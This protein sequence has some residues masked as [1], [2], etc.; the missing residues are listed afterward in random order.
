MKNMSNEMDI[1]AMDIGGMTLKEASAMSFLQWVAK[2]LNNMKAYSASATE[3]SM[4]LS[5]PP[6]TRVMSDDQKLEIIAKMKKAGIE[7]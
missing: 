2:K 5:N 6:M 3:L 7:I 1:L 4:L